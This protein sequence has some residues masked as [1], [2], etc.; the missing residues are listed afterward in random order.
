MKKSIIKILALTFVVVMACTML[1]SCFGPNADPDK[2][3][4]SL[5]DAG[6]T[7]VLNKGD[8]LI[9]G[10]LLPDGVDATLVAYKDGEYIAISYYEEAADA[11]DAWEDAQE[12]AAKLE[13]KYEGIVCKKFGKMIYV[14]T[15]QA[16][17]DAK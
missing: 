9:S 7:V 11:N 8:G 3:K 12:E 5:E 10:A 13:E 4:A 17:K 14:G 6:Y 1:V 15:E 2:A 16:V